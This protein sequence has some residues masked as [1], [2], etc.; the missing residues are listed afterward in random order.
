MRTKK[1]NN[2]KK[3]VNL[4]LPAENSVSVCVRVQFSKMQYYYYCVCVC[5]VCV[6]AAAIILQLADCTYNNVFV[7]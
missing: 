1:N 3:P 2:D 6:C 4:K 7:F 5:C